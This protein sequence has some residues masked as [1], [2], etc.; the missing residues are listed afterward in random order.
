MTPCRM[1]GRY[2]CGCSRSE[3][4]HF[5]SVEVKSHMGAEARGA[6]CHPHIYPRLDLPRD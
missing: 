1:N 6:S 2:G 3:S 4:E 5:F